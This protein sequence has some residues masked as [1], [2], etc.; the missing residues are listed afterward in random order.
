MHRDFP[1]PT[2][3]TIPAMELKATGSEATASCPSRDGR[4]GCA[5]CASPAPDLRQEELRKPTIPAL[6][7]EENV[8]Q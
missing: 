5:L 6:I 1:T 2:H 3:I 8:G 7:R 4:C